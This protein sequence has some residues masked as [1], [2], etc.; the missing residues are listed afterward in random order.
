MDSIARCCRVSHCFCS[1]SDHVT[2]A[3]Q[4]EAAKL[5]IYAGISPSLTLPRSESENMSVIHFAAKSTADPTKKIEFLK[6]LISQHGIPIDVEGKWKQMC[7]V[8]LF[9]D[10]TG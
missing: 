1:Y 6:Y 8:D 10:R 4:L 3:C 9:L 2:S 5:F 7:L